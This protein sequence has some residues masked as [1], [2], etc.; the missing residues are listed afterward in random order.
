MGL[1]RSASR[2]EVD[3]P[4]RRTAF[5]NNGDGDH[6]HKAGGLSRQKTLVRPERQRSQRVPL[7][8]NAAAGPPTA[9]VGATTTRLGKSLPQAETLVTYTTP[10][11]P[12]SEDSNWWIYISRTMTCCVWPKCMEAC[13]MTDKAVQQA[14]REKAA[15]CMIIGVLCFFVSFFTFGLKPVL[16]PG[17]ASS[18]TDAYFNQT[19]HISIPYRDDVIIYGS[20]YD[21]DQTAR[22]LAQMGGIELTADWRGVDITRLFSSRPS[23]DCMNRL[24][25]TPTNCSVPN[26]FPASPALQPLPDGPCPD[27]S[28]LSGMKAKKRLFFFWGEV[29]SNVVPPHALLVF[30]GVVLNM[31][32]LLID[33]ALRESE[34]M[35]PLVRRINKGLGKDVTY[36]FYAS[37]SGRET[38]R[39]LQ[40]QYQV[41]YVDQESSGCAVYQTVMILMLVVIM[42]V[43]ACRFLMALAFYYFFSESIQFSKYSPDYRTAASNRNSEPYHYHPGDAIPN[44]YPRPNFLVKE[45]DMYTMLLVTCYSEGGDGIRGT[46]ESLAETTY[47]DDHKLLFVIADGMIKGDDW[48]A[49]GKT[50]PEVILDMIIQD[51]DLGEA[52]GKSYLAIADGAKQHNMAKVYAGYFPHHNRHVPI[53]V[54]VKCGPPSEQ[55]AAKPG[56]RGKR[57]SQLILMNFLSRVLFDDRMTPLDHDLY[58]KICHITGVTPDVYETVLMVDADTRVSPMSLKHMNG[59][60]RADEG[61]MGLCGETRI[62]NKRDSWVTMIQVFEYYI[63]HHLGKAFESVFG[64]VTCLPG[65]FCMYRITAR[66]GATTVPLLVNPDI[67]EEYSENV[68]DTLHKKNLLLLGEDRFLTTLMLRSFPKRKMV[69]VPKAVC[70]TVVPDKF[71][72]LL[73]QRRRWINSTIHNL[74]ELVLLKDLCGIFCFSMQF[75]I[76]LEL[77]GTTILPATLIS[78]YVLILTS[79]VSPQLLPLILLATTMLLPGILISLTTRKWIYVGYLLIYLLALPVWNFILPVYAFWKFDDFSWGETRRVVGEDGGNHGDKVGEYVVGSVVLKRYGVYFANSHVTIIG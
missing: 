58:R 41:G 70:H 35:V 13:G 45:A 42:G 29:S 54:V 15:L 61:I 77:L 55:S 71:R 7:L 2:F 66:K 5:A 25:L 30:N 32:S 8:R 59:A 79:T 24:G 23:D 62:A 22:M 1:Q 34:A 20:L 12:P 44:A 73:S 48:Q 6:D 68:V 9:R 51:P 11:P 46:L 36:S 27:P 37:P 56:N 40:N 49:T 43:V 63:S 57:D 60:M 53:I 33:L 3:L 50:T 28:W 75:V 38:M 47:P 39:C 26:P 69:F 65:C 17:G 78:L 16:C 64:G 72:V 31:T 76:A 18:A 67:V 21:F 10:Q 14:W 4:R 19:D 52:A 74:L